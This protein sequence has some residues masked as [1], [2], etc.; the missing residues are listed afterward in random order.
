MLYNLLLAELHEQRASTSQLTQSPPEVLAET[1]RNALKVW[2]EDPEF[3]DI[4]TWSPESF[5][6]EVRGY[7]H[8]IRMLEFWESS[9]YLLNFMK[10]YNLKGK[11]QSCLSEG[12]AP[13]AEL[14]ELLRRHPRGLLRKSW[15]E[16]Y[17]PLEPSNA[18]LRLLL[19][20]TLDSGLWRLL[21]L[22]PSLPYWRPEGPFAH[23]RQERPPTGRS[24]SAHSSGPWYPSPPQTDSRHRA[25][26]PG[27][28]A[29]P[30]RFALPWAN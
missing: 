1:Y 16:K 26:A 6:P 11:V 12:G 5:W 15:L 3:E 23:A 21:W 18:R 22:P 14:R 9:P 4:V 25:Q 29:Y 8:T 7:G 24:P 17:A 30:T 2:A 20:E 19:Q 27:A 13:A 28:R 10:G